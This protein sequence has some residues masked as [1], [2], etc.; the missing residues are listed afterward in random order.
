MINYVIVYQSWEAYN[1]ET[2]D[3]AIKQFRADRH[4]DDEIIEVK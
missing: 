1:A 3:D 4:K 2:V